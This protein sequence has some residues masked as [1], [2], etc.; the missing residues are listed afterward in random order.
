MK[1]LLLQILMMIIVTY[2]FSW[3]IVSEGKKI[4]N[5]TKKK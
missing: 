1:I 4:F 5:E 3:I 2:V